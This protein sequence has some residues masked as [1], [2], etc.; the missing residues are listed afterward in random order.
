[1]IDYIAY[2]YKLSRL[3]KE[4]RAIRKKY[5]PLIQNEHPQDR[6]DILFE[7]HTELVF[8]EDKIHRIVTNR[9]W[10]QA[11]RLMIPIPS[12]QDDGMW[13]PTET[14]PGSH[15]LSAKGITTL[16]EAIRAEKQAHWKFA[17]LWIAPV[18]GLIGACTGLIA[19]I[20]R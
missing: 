1:M 15:H 17:I 7:E 14:E 18:T 12:S 11:K 8:V 9:L 6:G 5:E 2:K 4:R 19:V 10:E 20:T 16:R 3:F 13:E